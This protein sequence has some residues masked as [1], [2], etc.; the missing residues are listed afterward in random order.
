MGFLFLFGVFAVLLPK[1]GPKVGKG[2]STSVVNYFWMFQ[3]CFV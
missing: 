3:F 1:Q 2:I